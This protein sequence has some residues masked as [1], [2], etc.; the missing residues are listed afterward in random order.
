VGIENG[1]H[2]N[3]FTK[4]ISPSKLYPTM[5][6]IH[7]GAFCGG[8]SHLDNYSPDYL[9][10]SDIVLVTFNYRL[11]PMGFL[12]LKDSQLGVPGN[13]G[14]KDQLMVL[15]F[16]KENIENFGGDPN[17]VTLFGH[18]A[19]GA[20]VSWHCI[21]EKSRNFFHR[22]IIM[23]GCVLN[24]WAFT[25]QRDWAYRLA[26]ALG[27][28]GNKEDEENLLQFLQKA[29]AAKMIEVQRVILRRDEFGK[30]SFPFAPHIEP[31]SSPDT[32][33]SQPPIDLVRSAWSNEIDILIG[34]TSDE[35]L[36]Y[37]ETLR[38]MPNIIASLALENMVPPDVMGLSQDDPIR[39]QFAEKLRENYYSSLEDSNGN[40]SQDYSRPSKDELAFCKVIIRFL[41]FSHRHGH[42]KKYLGLIKGF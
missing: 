42:T 7:G 1:L 24:L 38:D 30:I 32:F 37:L 14:L 16:V 18:S 27:Y 5:V 28:E 26:K 39:L 9:L 31:F 20:S 13:A 35:G 11:G 34:G 4:N 40:G 10:M 2:L 36:M 33:I 3:I 22:A 29:D 6:Y 12:H 23:S 8:G 25:P 19:G 15:K 17:N 21:S 41:F